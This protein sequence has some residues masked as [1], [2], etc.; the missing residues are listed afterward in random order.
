MKPT[1]HEILTLETQVWEA[2]K[3]GD[4]VLDAKMLSDDFL[5]VYPSGFSN[6]QQ[7]C[8][9]LKDGPTVASYELKTPRL[10]PL[11]ENRV[12]LSYLAEWS[13]LKDGKARETA[14]MYI[15]SIWEIIGERWQNTFSQ[16]TPAASL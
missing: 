1:L 4:P 10:I 8:D 9:Q 14:R 7:H 13:P 15:S 11:G 5:G 2:L 12:L 6:R 16:D 3:G